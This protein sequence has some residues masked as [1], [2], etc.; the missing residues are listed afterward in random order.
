MT[1]IEWAKYARAVTWVLCAVAWGLLLLDSIPWGWDLE[2]GVEGVVR[3]VAVVTS[4][5]L[6][7][8]RCDRQSQPAQEIYMA[9]YDA[10]RRAAAEALRARLGSTA[11]R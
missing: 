10:G 6:V 11:D 9:G 8:T 2:G 4:L 3:G 7:I 1:I 5:V